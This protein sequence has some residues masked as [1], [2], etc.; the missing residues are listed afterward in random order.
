[1]RR[2]F[3]AEKQLKTPREGDGSPWER[4][5]YSE[6]VRVFFPLGFRRG[7]EVVEESCF[8]V[9]EMLRPL[10]K[11]VAEMGPSKRCSSSVLV[12]LCGI[13]S[14]KDSEQEESSHEQPSKVSVRY[15]VP[16]PQ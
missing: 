15:K 9:R 11:V 14:I 3:N 7:G 10:P 5:G 16:R 12:F 6:L 1:M 8:V 13:S 4:Q 2:V